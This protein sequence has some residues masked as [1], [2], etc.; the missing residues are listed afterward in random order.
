MTKLGECKKD[1]SPKAL[2]FCEKFLIGK[3]KSDKSKWSAYDYGYAFA[4]YK[5]WFI[6][7]GDHPALDYK[8]RIKVSNVQTFTIPNG[9]PLFFANM[10]EG[11]KRKEFRYTDETIELEVFSFKNEIVDMVAVFICDFFLFNNF[12]T[13]QSK[14]FGSFYLDKSDKLYKA[15][16]LLY[17]F[18]IKTRGDAEEQWRILFKKLDLLHKLLRA[19]INT[20]YSQ[21]NPFYIKPVIFKYAIDRGL[22][23]DKKSI[24]QA[25]YP[26]KLNE[27]ENNHISTDI[28]SFNQSNRPLYLFKDMLGLST[29][30]EWKKP[31]YTK[32]TKTNPDISRFTSPIHYKI[33]KLDD[34]TYS[35]Y[36]QG[37]KIP[38]RYLNQKFNIETNK[39][40]HLELITYP[41]FDIEDFL[42]YAFLDIKLEDLLRNNSLQ[43]HKIF[44]E[45]K[46]IF[47]Q[48]KANLK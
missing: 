26:H 14:G 3:R 6:S 22:Q 28:L 31:F 10:G 42:K 32:I 23:W 45:L 12:G 39:G 24:K 25:Y 4:K 40:N 48:I 27:Q 38:E 2:D 20:S 34:N 9:F 36:F 33:I 16:G 30:E 5:N 17:H 35:I 15:S 13:R 29:L 1:F 8:M 46:D 37:V 21:E 44:L 11:I 19:G 18:K 43:N 41:D 7:Q 47:D